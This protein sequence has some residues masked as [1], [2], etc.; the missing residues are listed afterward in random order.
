MLSLVWR[1]LLCNAVETV[2]D[3]TDDADC[4]RIVGIGLGRGIINMKNGAV[5]RRL[6]QVGVVLHQVIADT[7][8]YIG[9][10][11]TAADIIIRLQTGTAQCATVPEVIAFLGRGAASAAISALFVSKSTDL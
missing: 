3:I 7:N 1:R 11:K 4:D 8:D 5:A 6:P 9:L 10:V 2:P